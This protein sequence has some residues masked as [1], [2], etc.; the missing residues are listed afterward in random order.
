MTRVE[1]LADLQRRS[2]AQLPSIREPL[3]N[4]EVDAFPE[5]D[6]APATVLEPELAP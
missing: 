2:A 5:L 1:R 4:P 3:A 6:L